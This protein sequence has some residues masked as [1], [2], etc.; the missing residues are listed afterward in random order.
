[1]SRIIKRIL[2]I[3]L[4]AAAAFALAPGTY[5]AEEFQCPV[6]A[7]RV[8]IYYG[9]TWGVQ[10][11]YASANLQNVTGLGYGYSLGYFDSDRSFVPL[12]VYIKDTNKISICVD[13]NVYWDSSEKSYELGSS[14]SVVVGC[15]HVQIPGSH[16]NYSD[17][18]AAARG[19]T[20]YGPTFIKYEN[21]RFY[22]CV[23]N[24]TNTSQAEELSDL[25]GN[26]SYVTSGTENTVTVVETGTDKIL[27][28]FDYS[29]TYHLGVR[30]IETS[31]EKCQTWFKNRT[32]YGD[33]TYVRLS[34]GNM[35]VVNVVP[36]EDYVKGVVPYEMSPSSPLEALKAQAVCARTYGIANLN[37][38]KSQGF[39]VCNTSK[40]QVYRGT[41]RANTN[42]NRAVDETA[43]QYLTY[44]GKLCSTYYYSY[45]G[46][47]SESVEN[48]WTG[49]PVDYLVGVPDPYE[50]D[51]APTVS[52]YN[53]TVTF[54]GAD[55]AERLRKNGYS[56]SN[57]VKF[58]I[59]EYT[60]VGNVLKIRFTDADGKT[61]TFE[62]DK[63]RSI[64]GLKSAR[65]YINGVNPNTT[66]LYVNSDKSF[67]TG[68]L[69]GLSAIGSG[70]IDAIG[71]G[72]VYAITGTGD[73]ELVSQNTTG[74]TASGSSFVI[75]GSGNGHS[76]G[77]SQTGA[78]SM[79][80]FYDKT[81]DEILGFYYQGTELTYSVKDSVEHPDPMSAAGNTSGG[82]GTIPGE[83]NGEV[84]SE[85]PAEPVQQQEDKPTRPYNP[86]TDKPP[87]S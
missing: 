65:Y 5:G 79:A 54:T 50:A 59:L 35:S 85:E 31:S 80:Q 48:V 29:G 57:I 49:G 44:K 53:W 30:P 43:G 45:N 69:S 84:G 81:Y 19:Y 41:E 3:L 22:V 11:D 75:N 64:L 6:S 40:C 34:N 2:S 24:C 77:L 8:G 78:K 7:I 87:V 52:G 83:V 27:F 25:I 58:Q 10:E 60:A 76:V 56:C 67:I 9:A 73:V 61:F 55:I 26:D 63:C 23:G 17:A 36:I 62:R 39:D 68:L 13:R 72:D 47:A 71:S 70:G 38:Y 33:F 32:Y 20:G 37:K 16:S 4:V 1:M 28:E 12:G 14:G 82:S 66:V 15:Y 51:L 18:Q 21:G 86:A 74:G 46:G 42:T